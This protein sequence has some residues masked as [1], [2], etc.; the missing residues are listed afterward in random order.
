MI[1]TSQVIWSVN[2]LT[3]FYVT[4]T[5]A[6]M[7]LHTFCTACI[8][9]WS[10]HVSSVSGSCPGAT[11]LSAFL[12]LRKLKFH[13]QLFYCDPQIISDQCSF[14]NPLKTSK[15]IEAKKG[16]I[17]LQWVMTYRIYQLIKIQQIL[18]GCKSSCIQFL[19]YLIAKKYLAKYYFLRKTYSCW[20]NYFS[21]S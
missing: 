15:K 21:L 14:L 17:D 3:R 4:E 18:S 2:Q 13:A 12:A 20:T 16:N 11:E 10:I 7:R 1:E 8:I 6:L 9:R 5:L 19:H